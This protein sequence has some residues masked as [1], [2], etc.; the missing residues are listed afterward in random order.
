MTGSRVDLTCIVNSNLDSPKVV[1]VLA[2][3]AIFLARCLKS[4]AGVFLDFEAPERRC[5]TRRLLHP[6]NCFSRKNLGDSPSVESC[7]IIPACDVL[8]VRKVERVPFSELV[9]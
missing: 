9:M 8:K 2:I 3:V 1:I 7:S 5:E 4:L 6:Y